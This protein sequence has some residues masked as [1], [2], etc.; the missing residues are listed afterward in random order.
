MKESFRKNNLTFQCID[1][2]E[3]SLHIEKQGLVFYEKA[4]GLV[5]DPRVKQIFTQLAKEEKEHIQT[6]N[7]KA[8]FLQ[9]AVSKRYEIRRQVD[10]FI[11]YELSGKVF[12]LVTGHGADIGDIKSDLEALDVGI[13]SEKR[14]ISV[15]TKLMKEE[16]KI[17]V[18]AIFSHLIV[19]EKKHLEA[20]EEIKKAVISETLAGI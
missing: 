12:P 4:S 9:P 18:R 20:L 3:V 11:A 1:A 15:L 8:K 10:T 16:K 6:L 7:V 14:S 17:D 13:E 5:T 2:I 19:E